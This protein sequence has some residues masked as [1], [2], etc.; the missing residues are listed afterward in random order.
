MRR[1]T[2]IHRVA[3][4]AHDPSYKDIFVILFANVALHHIGIPHRAGTRGIFV[5]NTKTDLFTFFCAADDVHLK[6]VLNV[7]NNL[8]LIYA[9]QV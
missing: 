7:I 5:S 9:A 4:C 8:K 2:L 3:Q 1:I 6:G